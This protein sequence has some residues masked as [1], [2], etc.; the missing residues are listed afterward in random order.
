MR[1]RVW[2]GLGLG[3]KVWCRLGLELGSGL[4]FGVG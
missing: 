4:G 3:A 2:C 1:V